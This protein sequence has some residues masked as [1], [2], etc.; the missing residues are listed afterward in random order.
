MKQHYA[1]RIPA[2]L[3]LWLVMTAAASAQLVV[4]DVIAS[5]PTA[6][7][8]TNV[9]L[10]GTI[11]QTLIGAASAGTTAGGFGFWYSISAPE[12][13]AVREERLDGASAAAS[14]RCSPNPFS[15]Q[16]E[17]RMT[18]PSRGHVVLSLFDAAGRLVETLIDGDR[19]AGTIAVQ[20]GAEDLASGSYTVQ[21]R[22]GNTHQAIRLSVVK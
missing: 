20:L 19:E 10:V 3:V 12:P 16:T 6:A 13:G 18:I 5:G 9:A 21:L 1:M 14:L 7:I 2:L 15:T 8:G 11:G 4:R 17:I 22:S